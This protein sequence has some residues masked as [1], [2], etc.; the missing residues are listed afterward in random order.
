MFG[1]SLTKSICCLLLRLR[2]P[3]APSHRLWE[4]SLLSCS[5]DLET[6]RHHKYY[7]TSS[8]QVCEWIE[9]PLESL[10]KKYELLFF[11]KRV[12]SSLFGA[13]HDRASLLRRR[14]QLAASPISPV[15]RRRNF[16]IWQSDNPRKQVKHSRVF[17]LLSHSNVVL[18]IERR[19]LKGK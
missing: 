1:S 19:V 17:L 4:A 9:L 18:N 13:S 16:S 14:R 5:T 10:L 12:A 3:F 8:L 7:R 11:V 15:G 2:F 6:S